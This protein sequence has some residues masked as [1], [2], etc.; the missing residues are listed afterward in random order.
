MSSR[1]L[2]GHRYELGPRIGAGGMA[3]VFRG[4]DT[5][6]KR[7]VA[8]KLLRVEVWSND[9]RGV[10]RFAREGEA[11]RQLNHPN[12]VKLLDQ[13]DEGDN[14][15][16]VMELVEGGSFDTLCSPE[17][18]LPLR[19][20]LEIALDVCDALVRAHRLGIVHRDLKPANVLIAADGAA[21]LTDFG[22]AHVAGKERLSATDSV[23]GTVDY[24]SPEAIS[25]GLVDARADIW[26][27]GVL[28]FEALTGVRPFAGEHP[29]ATVHAI[30]TKAPA[31][32]ETLRADCPLALVDLVYRMLE[33]DRNQRVPSTRQVGVELE[34]IAAALKGAPAKRPHLA[35]FD[36]ADTQQ[37]RH[38][39]S[40]VFDET[41]VGG[42]IVAPRPSARTSQ[43]PLQ[44]TEF[45]GRQAELVALRQLLVRDRVRLL[46]I[47]GPGGMGKSR[48]ALEACRRA[49]LELSRVQREPAAQAWFELGPCFVELA[50]LASADLVLSSIAEAVGFQIHPGG[51]APKRQL[52]AFLARRSFLLV[53]DN[54]EHVLPAADLVAE[55]L[56][57]APGVSVLVTSREPLGLSHEHVF[58]LSG[59]GVPNP[60]GER[61][62]DYSG[63]HLFLQS[64]RR[65]APDFELHGDAAQ[66]AA[67]ICG[68]VQG[69][70]L[71]IV[72]AAS[73]V[74]MLSLTEIAQEIAANGEFLSSDLRDVPERHKSIR[75]VF[76]YSFHLLSPSERAVMLRLGVF[77]GGF[78]R[79]AAQST[80]LADLRILA[81][82]AK[83][84]LISR[85]PASG[86]YELHEL[87]RQYAEDRLREDPEEHQRTLDRH[88]S[89]FAA[90]LA[91]RTAA[92]QSNDPRPAARAIE[93]ELDNVRNAWRQLLARQNLVETA[94]GLP[95]L[96][97][98]YLLR[99]SFSELEEVFSTAAVALGEPPPA[100]GSQ[101]A[102]LHGHALV[103]Q[104]SAVNG[105]WDFERAVAL[106]SRALPELAPFTLESAH[107]LLGL[108]LA[109]MSSGH[110]ERG[111]EAGQEALALYAETSDTWES[112]RA[113]ALLGFS[114]ADWQGPDKT[115]ALFERSIELQRSMGDGQLTIPEA[116]TGL[117]RV[118]VERGEYVEGCRLI[119]DSLALHEKQE[120][121]WGK[122]TALANLATTLRKQGAY[123]EAEAHAQEALALSREFFP[124]AEVFELLLLA[125]ILKESDRLAEASEH[126][127]ACL[128][129]VA[130]L[131]A[132]AEPKPFSVEL[133]H[134]AVCVAIAQ[135]NLGDIAFL[136]GDPTEARRLLRE[137][138]G[139]FERLGTTWGVA[140]A[141]DYLGYLACHEGDEPGAIAQLGRALDV[142]LQAGLLPHAASALAGVARLHFKLGA[143]ELASELVAVLR[144]HPA[145]ERQTLAR[146]VE[147]LLI[148]LRRSYPSEALEQ[149][150]ERGKTQ[151]L[152][153]AA[154]AQLGSP[155]F[156]NPLAAAG[157]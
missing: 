2:I 24:M 106:L 131:P 44:A 47:V 5:H 111:I 82:L 150:L 101:Q 129:G 109:L 121:R 123:A 42:A 100:P 22:V 78:T 88:A 7:P 139:A 10:A 41:L 69:M 94:A 142:S 77:R 115:Q 66:A 19:R 130:L 116:L 80:A 3:T 146:R 84:S 93:G 89:F 76:D 81:V 79:E 39:E 127:H 38:F 92:L 134:P 153:R 53:L 114:Y 118:K 117:G 83:K 56:Q 35:G 154:R 67:H 148:E 124:F 125:D 135:L 13:V 126:Y 96:K 95:A 108:A 32:L 91:C 99:G 141:S 26:S 104:A 62:A 49:D 61:D 33:K 37:G 17:N 140:V 107:A 152:E 113:H 1:T 85:D 29:I 45:V 122:R 51:P 74:N 103:L 4:L 112:A 102:R 23:I 46:T 97:R 50:P 55:I 68:L 25:G 145:V 137:S 132:E 57:G 90:F 40:F 65:L 144:N 151:D 14:H 105:Q 20:V 157:R 73:W 143:L 18:K 30:V 87:L 36:V 48:L 149:V 12:I 31:D 59:L 147:P 120:N 72:L 155:L 6:T 64:A 119:R 60:A 70:P 156:A 58:P 138:L 28:I 136:Q 8:L 133:G 71:G 11:L 52:V 21:C 15:Y 54:F 86:R 16:L 9:P 75:A 110:P 34:S 27:L 128:S 63:I 43:L 98:F